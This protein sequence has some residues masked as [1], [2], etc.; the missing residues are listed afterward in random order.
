MADLKF[1]SLLQLPYYII[2]DLFIGGWMAD[3]CFVPKVDIKPGLNMM[4]WLI[5]TAENGS[6]TADMIY[7]YVEGR[8]KHTVH[9]KI[10]SS[11]V[12]DQLFQ[13]IDNATGSKVT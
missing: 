3:R 5:R 4:P 13:E 9:Q 2:E 8:F 1:V 7:H 10:M 6:A 12:R 11:I